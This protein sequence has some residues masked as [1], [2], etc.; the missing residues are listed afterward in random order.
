MFE[1]R[2]SAYLIEMKETYNGHGVKIT[3]LMKEAA[4]LP[5]TRREPVFGINK[6]NLC[7]TGT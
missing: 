7:L 2:E 4:E 1:P 3:T 5:F 6:R